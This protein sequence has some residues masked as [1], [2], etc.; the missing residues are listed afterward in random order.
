M[1]VVWNSVS[2]VVAVRGN[3]GHLPSLLRALSHQDYLGAVELVVVDNHDQ[4]VIDRCRLV[5]WPVPV[6]VAFEMRPGLARA[7]NT[8]IRMATGDFILITDPEAQPDPGWVRTMV[9]ALVHGGADLVGGQVVPILPAGAGPLPAPVLALFGPACWPTV[10]CELEAPGQLSGS[11]LG[12]P[13][14]DEVPLLVDARR[15]GSGYHRHYDAIELPASVQPAGYSV[16]L[17]PGAVVR[18]P[19]LPE[20]LTVRSVW[21]RAWRQGV[22]LARPG[23]RRSSGAHLPGPRAPRG[24]PWEWLVSRGGWLAIVTVLARAAGRTKERALR[25][26]GW[27]R[28]ERPARAR[29]LHQHTAQH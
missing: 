16:Q 23:V 18:R 29:P 24:L 20:H 27:R 28:E 6:H 8:G 11:N 10:V 25:A 14:T 5:A 3:A 22:S 15:R 19:V 2:V 9:T 4:P 12:M 26:L 1:P 7:R 17:V 13:N 21:V